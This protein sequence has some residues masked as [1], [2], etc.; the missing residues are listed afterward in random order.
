MQFS[1][2]PI[3]LTTVALLAHANAHRENVTLTRDDIT[4]HGTLELPGGPG[5]HPVA[6]IIA[7]SGP[8][9]RDGNSATLPGKNDSLKLLA[10]SLAAKGIASLRYDKRG[11]GESRTAQAEQDLTFD[12][13]VNDAAAWLQQLQRDPRFQRVAVIGHSE[14]ALVGLLAAK[15]IGADA[16]VS[17]AAPGTNAAGTIL[18]QLRAN[19]ANPSDLIAEAERAVNEL[20]A[21]RR[22]PQV[23]PTL[24][25]LFRP[26]VQPYLIGWFKY[27]PARE[28]A[29]LNTPALI[30][31]GDRDLQVGVSDAQRLKAAQPEATLGIIPGMNHV[32]KS[33]PDNPQGNL[34]SYSDPTLALAPGLVDRLTEFLTA[35]LK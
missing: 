5:P 2:H 6:L 15:K 3:A 28:I 24:A 31:Q 1:S 12:T 22:V 19:P 34:A 18:R 16:Y 20:R 26:S 25:P 30:L 17:I 32:L 8:T 27:D 7:G 23:N 13:F 14:G 10:R 11:V 29:T 35:H 9:D 21:G 4:L 33:V